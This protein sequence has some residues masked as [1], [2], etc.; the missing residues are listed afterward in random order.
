MSNSVLTQIEDGFKQLSPS[1]QQWLIERLIHHVHEATMRQSNDVE[2]ELALMAT[3]PQIQNELREIELE[4]S[5][6]ES[7]GLETT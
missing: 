7:D 2:E 1:E 3:D 6:V 4:F 5:D